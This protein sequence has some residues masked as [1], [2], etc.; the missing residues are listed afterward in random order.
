MKYF[1]YLVLTGMALICHACQ[2]SHENNGFP[3]AV[4]FK[5]DGGTVKISGDDS[6]TQIEIYDSDSTVYS[7]IKPE[8]D[9]IY[10]NYGWLTARWRIADKDIYITA[11][12]NGSEK[13]RKVK[14]YG[15]MGYEY[16]VIQVSQKH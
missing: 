1:I 12:P 11:A 15:Y 9:S 4:S 10:L 8:R 14:L 6:I 5:K 16:A 13:N 3:S 7:V 2:L